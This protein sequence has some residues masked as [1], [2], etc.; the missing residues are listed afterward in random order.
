MKLYNQSERFY[1]LLEEMKRTHNAK[2]HDYANTK[3]VFANFRTCELAA[4]Q[5]GKVVVFVLVT[6][7][8]ASWDLQRKRS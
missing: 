6:S 8:V 3:D 1:E 4:F 7:L 5:H 2:R